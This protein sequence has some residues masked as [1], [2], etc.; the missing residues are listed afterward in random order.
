MKIVVGKINVLA[1]YDTQNR[2]LIQK[3]IIHYSCVQ[4]SMTAISGI[5]IK[6]KTLKEFTLKLIHPKKCS[7]K[8]DK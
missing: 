5:F 3:V 6:N 7:I 8:F 1:L 4:A 2:R